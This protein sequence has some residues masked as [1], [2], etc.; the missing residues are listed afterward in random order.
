MQ[1]RTYL[2]CT[3]LFMLLA[4]LAAV[5]INLVVDPYAITGASRMSGF[6]EYKIDINNRVRLMKKYNPL[7][8]QHNALIVGNSRVE[9]GISPGNQCFKEAGMT[10]YNLGVP[11]AT[12][13]QQLGY[14]L[15]VIYQQPIETV[16]L[17]L[18]FTDFIFTRRHARFEELSLLD[19]REDGLRYDASGRENP[20]YLRTKA[21]DY[22]QALFSLDSLVSS[23]KTV[24]LQD[25]A[26]PDR[27]DAGFNPARD[28][29]ESVRVEGPRALFDQKMVDL[30]EHFS[31]RWFLR[32]DDGRLDPGFE[33][34]RHFLDLA[35]ERELRVHLF[36]NPF[37]AI[38]WNLLRERNYMPLNEKWLNEVETLV[39]AYPPDIVSLWD[40]SGD[41]RFIHEEVPPASDRSGP[42]RWFWEPSHYRDELGDRMIEAMLVEECAA[43]VAFGRRLH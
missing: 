26:A 39:G 3:I 14:A 33:D 31:V 35:V 17:S 9:I 24:A 7:G 13:R 36:I 38:Y 37:H 32:D 19:Y 29:G 18:D 5:G 25:A 43:E 23:V 30:R 1:A 12:V 8:T 42:L 15:N 27:D 2:L 20:D 10:L 34:L 41:S 16:F 4:A 11:G 22:Y 40:F 28:F 21:L 6:N